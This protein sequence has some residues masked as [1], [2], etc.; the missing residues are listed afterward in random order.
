M[1]SR[2]RSTARSALGAAVAL[3]AVLFCALPAEARIFGR[4]FNYA[5]VVT[6]PALP[7]RPR[8]EQVMELPED[9]DSWHLVLIV[10]G[11][12][13]GQQLLEQMKSTPRLADVASKVKFHAY[14]RDHWWVQRYMAEEATPV[15]Y[16]CDETGA[17]VYKASGA[18]LPASGEEL[19][20]EIESSV[21]ARNEQC[22]PNCPQP[23]PETRPTLFTKPA[24]RIPDARPAGMSSEWQIGAG[25][26]ALALFA[27]F[28]MRRFSK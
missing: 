26:I 23:T 13:T 18:N 7:Q 22:G 8:Q 24:A 3:A 27:A 14:G 19:A 11:S 15:V 20:D 21:W 4:G 25:L 5:P 16:L 6:R 1:D 9:G 12:A 17:R 10:D 2:V 28:V